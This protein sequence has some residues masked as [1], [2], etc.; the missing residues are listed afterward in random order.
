[1]SAHSARRFLPEAPP[2]R[3]HCPRSRVARPQPSGT[4]ELWGGT[5]RGQW[6]TS[7]AS[8]DEGPQTSL[9]GLDLL[10][11]CFGVARKLGM[12]FMFSVVQKLK[13]NNILWHVEMV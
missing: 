9:V 7:S 12:V 10:T 8:S 6:G 5:I 13:A 11:V 4:Q 2:E 1:M 3:R